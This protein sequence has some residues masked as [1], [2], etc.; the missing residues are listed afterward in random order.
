MQ[1]VA[2]Q[3][4]AGRGRTSQARPGQ[5]K[6]VRV[7]AGRAGYDMPRHG[8]AGQSRAGAED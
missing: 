7:G 6:T 3:S 5:G 2:G 1:C 4:V 8:K